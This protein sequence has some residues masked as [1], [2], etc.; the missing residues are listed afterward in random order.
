MKIAFILGNGFDVK[1]GI[2]TKYPDFYGFFLQQNGAKGTISDDEEEA[3]IN[4]LELVEMMQSTSSEYWSDLELLFGSWIKRFKSVDSVRREKAYLEQQ[5]NNYLR[6]QQSRV[7]INDKDYHNLKVQLDST[8]RK[9]V[10]LC[11]CRDKNNFYEVKFITFNYTDVI[12]R[13][14]KCVRETEHNNIVYNEPCHVH[15]SI[16][17]TVILGVDNENQY[18]C[19]KN[20]QTAREL[21]SIMQKKALNNTI[22]PNIVCEIKKA[23]LDTEAVIIYGASIGETDATWWRIIS[24]WLFMSSEHRV[25]IIGHIDNS[26]PASATNQAQIETYEERFRRQMPAQLIRRERRN[27]I[28]VYKCEDWMFNFS[29]S[30]VSVNRGEY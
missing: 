11:D 1:I 17:E 26:Y 4:H 5:I 10:D 6:M 18:E 24:D 23:I 30:V 19:P 8:I 13:I 29:P 3:T 15:G 16:D 7:D 9:F 25:S 12:D 28:E 21:K 27:M 22:R 14:V 2:D 20:K